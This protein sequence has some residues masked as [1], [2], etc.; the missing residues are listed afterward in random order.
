MSKATE[1]T[2]KKF[3]LTYRAA[4]AAAK[5]KN[6]QNRFDKLLRSYK[7]SYCQIWHHTTKD[8][9]NPLSGT[10]LEKRPIQGKER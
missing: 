4:K 7:C 10:F 5:R 3:Y 2:G 6:S 9:I 1:C 8:K